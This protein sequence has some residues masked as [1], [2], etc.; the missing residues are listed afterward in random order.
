MHPSQWKKQTGASRREKTKGKQKK[1]RN[2]KI[3]APFPYF[4][5]GRKRFRDP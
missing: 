5:F 2:I 1:S 4:F 3:I